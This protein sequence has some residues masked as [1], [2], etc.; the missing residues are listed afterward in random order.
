[1]KLL[2]WRKASDSYKV[3]MLDYLSVNLPIIY[4]IFITSKLKYAST[5][6]LV[7]MLL[8]SIFYMLSKKKQI[9]LE[10]GYFQIWEF[11]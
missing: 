3:Q 9:E 2:K 7:S 5:T 6:V 4:R 11:P 1:M 10:I 8:Y